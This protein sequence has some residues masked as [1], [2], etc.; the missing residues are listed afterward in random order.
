MNKQDIDSVTITIDRKDPRTRQL[1][2]KFFSARFKGDN[3]YNPFR[4]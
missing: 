1:L 2:T 4:K 3:S